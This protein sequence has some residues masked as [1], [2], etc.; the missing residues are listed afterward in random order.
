LNGCYGLLD[1]IAAKNQNRVI[2]LLLGVWEVSGSNPSPENDNLEVF[3]CFS[4][5][6]QAN[7]GIYISF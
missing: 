3:G 4:Q 2:S 6:L 1:L 7:V 5:F